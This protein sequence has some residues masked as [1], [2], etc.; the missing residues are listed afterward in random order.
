MEA[1]H[2]NESDPTQRRTCG[3]KRR[4]R[5]ERCTAQPMANGR[6]R[7][8]GGATP[9]GVAN[10]NF[11]HGRYSKYAPAALADRYEA[12]RHDPDRLA[13]LDELALV[14]ARIGLVLERVDEGAAPSLWR[15]IKAAEK[16]CDRARGAAGEAKAIAGLRAA[17][18]AGVSDYEAWDEVR[19]LIRDRRALVAAERRRLV[20]LREY[21]TAQQAM[22]LIAQLQS[23][24]REHVDDPD[25][26]RAIA[27][28][29][30]RLS[31]GSVSLGAAD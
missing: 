14:D 20:D 4:G 19:A 26:L 1:N 21:V 10:A 5:E 9:A 12:A 11:Q 17:V 28:D 31:S 30:R 22:T 8:H 24:V 18:R 13:M 6:C 27:A 2:M 7:L 29:L 3:A 23:V 25:T 16:A 15:R